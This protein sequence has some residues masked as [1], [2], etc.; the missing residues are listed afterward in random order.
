MCVYIYVWIYAYVRV[1]IYIKS[2]GIYTPTL[3]S[4]ISKLDALDAEG[5]GHRGGG[6]IT[7]VLATR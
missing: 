2:F 3:T 4:D 1:Y 6:G 7:L 5:C